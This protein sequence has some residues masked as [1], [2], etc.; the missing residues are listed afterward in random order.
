MVEWKEVREDNRLKKFRDYCFKIK[1]V[2]YSIMI[3]W[4]NILGIANKLID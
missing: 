2:D 3:Y 4:I 1:L